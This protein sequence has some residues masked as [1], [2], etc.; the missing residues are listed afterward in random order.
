[1]IVTWFANRLQKYNKDGATMNE[2]ARG[3]GMSPS[4]HLNDILWEMVKD[5][6]LDWREIHRPGRWVGREY[7]LH[8]KTYNYLRKRSINLKVNGRPEGQLELF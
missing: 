3:L 1:M 6:S 4:S 7:R 5:E 8:P 2:I